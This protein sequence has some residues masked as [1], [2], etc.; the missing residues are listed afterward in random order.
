MLERP[1]DDDEQAAKQLRRRAV[2][3]AYDRRV[4]RGQWKLY[5]LMTPR[6][7]QR[8]VELRQITQDEAE[9]RDTVER[10]ANELLTEALK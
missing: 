7:R 10:V 2:R 8:L 3:N 9:D 6:M 5:L 1:P 4:R